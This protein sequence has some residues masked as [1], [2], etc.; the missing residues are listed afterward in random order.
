MRAAGDGGD[1]GDGGAD[2]NFRW[3]LKGI[4]WIRCK[5]MLIWPNRGGREKIRGRKRTNPPLADQKVGK[6][7]GLRKFKPIFAP[8]SHADL[9]KTGE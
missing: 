6:T 8:Y 3:G 9:W 1:G 7:G 4:A 5:R 2:S